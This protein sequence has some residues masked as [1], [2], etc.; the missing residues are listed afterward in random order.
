[1]GNMK[2]TENTINIL[3]NFSFINRSLIVI[4]GNRIAIRNDD[5][6]ILA[7]AIVSETFPKFAIGDISKFLNIISLFDDPDF[8]FTESSVIIS[9]NN[10]SVEHVFSNPDVFDRTGKFRKSLEREKLINFNESDISFKLTDKEIKSIIKASGVLKNDFFVIEAIK[11][12]TFI[13]CNNIKNPSSD[14]YTFEVPK[15][16]NDNFRYVIKIEKMKLMSSDYNVSIDLN[17][18]VRFKKD[19]NLVYYIC[20]E[21]ENKR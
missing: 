14:R 20:T 6:S 7:E 15:S 8:N 19:E 21:K 18:I 2:I 11:N 13:H 10:H 12:R 3:K 9:E 17:G 16:F 5:I 4:P 1:M